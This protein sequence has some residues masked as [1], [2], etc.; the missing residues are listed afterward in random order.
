MRKWRISAFGI[1]IAAAICCEFVHIQSFAR[2]RLRLRSL[3]LT[4]R[5]MDQFSHLLPQVTLIVKERR[6]RLLFPRRF[7]IA[8]SP[9]ACATHTFRPFPTASRLPPH[10]SAPSSRTD[11]PGLRLSLIQFFFV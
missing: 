6:P 3:P 5:Y 4:L 9:L 2:T 10:F 8:G 1:Q 11:L 7:T